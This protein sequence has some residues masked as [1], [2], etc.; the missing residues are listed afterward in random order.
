MTTKD[1]F[2]GDPALFLDENGSYLLFKGGQ[3][4]MDQGLQNTVSISLHTKLGWWGNYLLK[5]ESQKIGS[6]Y[7]ET[8][9]QPI[10]DISSVSNIEKSSDNALKWMKDVK[11]ASKI[12]SE[13]SNPTSHRLNNIISIKPVGS[14]VQKFLVTENSIN[15]I[16]QA[17][18]PAHG[19]I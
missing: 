16:N 3:P 17:Q 11:L 14:D 4:V 5:N 13:A 10:V 7:E 2:Q 6:D 19:E 15:W 8:L 1:R 12:T 9:L 18:F